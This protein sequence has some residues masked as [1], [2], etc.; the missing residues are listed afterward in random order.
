MPVHIAPARSPKYCLRGFQKEVRSQLDY[1]QSSY[2][3]HFRIESLASFCRREW[4]ALAFFGGGF[5]VLALTAIFA[6]DPAFF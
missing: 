2:D 5:C 3:F 6:I 1:T 4:P